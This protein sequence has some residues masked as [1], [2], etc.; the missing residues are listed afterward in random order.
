M[1]RLLLRFA[2]CCFLRK[3]LF[4][5]HTKYFSYT[6]IILSLDVI[7]LTL[8]EESVFSIPYSLPPSKITVYTSTHC[9][10]SNREF[11][12]QT[13]YSSILCYSSFFTGYF[14]AHGIVG[15]DTSC[16]QI[17]VLRRPYRLVPSL[18]VGG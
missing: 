6:K 15:R 3:Y 10:H 5:L 11:I 17:Y 9:T 14:H 12:H 13:C 18:S 8:Y 4:R 1:R 7:D 16:A 2:T